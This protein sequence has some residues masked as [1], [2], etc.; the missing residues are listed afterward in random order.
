MFKKFNLVLPFDSNASLGGTAMNLRAFFFTRVLVQ[1][2]SL[3]DRLDRANNSEV[4]LSAFLLKVM[5]LCYISHPLT[6]NFQLKGE[7]RNTPNGWGDL[8]IGSQYMG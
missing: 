1:N 8:G 7:N 6:V 5:A 2:Y 4:A 3:P